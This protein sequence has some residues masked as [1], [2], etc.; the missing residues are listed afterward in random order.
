MLTLR[1]I[2]R[3]GN[4]V[5]YGLYDEEDRVVKLT[6]RD[7]ADEINESRRTHTALATIL[8][9]REG[10]A[11]IE[12]DGGA[13]EEPVAAISPD[14]GA[15]PAVDHTHPVPMHVHPHDHDISE[16]KHDHE[17]FSWPVRNHEHPHE[18]ELAKHE[19]EH[20]HPQREHSHEMPAHGHAAIDLRLLELESQTEA[21]SKHSHPHEHAH[22]HKEEFSE[23]YRRLTA[24]WDDLQGAL[25]RLNEHTHAQYLEAEL[26]VRPHRHDAYELQGHDH[27]TKAH[28][29]PAAEH[30]HPP[31]PHE[32]PVGTH[33]HPEIVGLFTPQ[34]AAGIELAPP[35]S[36][37]H[38]HRFDQMNAD[39]KGWV[40]G[41]CG[42]AKTEVTGG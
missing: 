5:R 20:S 32:H 27:A 29:H 1:V 37:A 7:A 13:E 23:F 34:T 26:P 38:I 42:V 4:M 11:V 19:H 21:L 2:S 31:E 10:A 8:A 30:H 41:I 22:D 39:G 40:C 36:G 14:L 35:L 3:D 6:V 18:H 17:E 12:E 9:R 28:E 25:S 33:L 16:L 24:L 15:T